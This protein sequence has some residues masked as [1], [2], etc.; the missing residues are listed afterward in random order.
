MRHGCKCPHIA[1]ITGSGT[2]EDFE[3]ARRLG[4]KTF[5][6]PVRVKDLE[7]WLADVEAALCRSVPSE[8]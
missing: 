5:L 4:M 3:R 7:E 8:S 2:E 1:L 6:K